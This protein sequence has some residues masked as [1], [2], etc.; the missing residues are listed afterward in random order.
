M[1]PCEQGM[2]R[3][4]LTYE[5]R[6]RQDMQ[7]SWQYDQQ[8]IGWGVGLGRTEVTCCIQTNASGYAARL[9]VG[10]PR[11]IV[12]KATLSFLLSQC[13]IAVLQASTEVVTTRVGH[14]ASCL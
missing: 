14:V 4:R 1:R 2:A 3:P 12:A 11:E 5:K 13:C 10:L 9:G 8:S 6:R 7:S